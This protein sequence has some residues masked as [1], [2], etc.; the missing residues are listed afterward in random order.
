MN[1]SIAFH[2]QLESFSAQLSDMIAGTC[3]FSAASVAM[4]TSDASNYRQIPLGVVYPHNC[5]DIKITVK[6]CQQHGHA[7]LMRGGGTSQNGQCVNNAVVI[8][9]SRFMTRVLNIDVETRTALI[10][11]ALSAM[12]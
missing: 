1:R 11:P 5:D 6:L 4:Y 12:P 10:E 2:P 9:C 3:D 7:V 8:D